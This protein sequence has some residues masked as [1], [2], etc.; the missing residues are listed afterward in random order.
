MCVVGG[1]FPEVLIPPPVGEPA[2]TRTGHQVSTEGAPD[3]SSHGGK[4]RVLPL[5]PPPIPAWVPLRGPV[6][7]HS[8]PGPN[9]LGG[10]GPEEPS[11]L[12]G[13]LKQVAAVQPHS[14]GPVAQLAQG[15]GYGQEVG[16]TA[17]AGR[18]KRVGRLQLLC[19]APR[20]CL[21]LTSS[22]CR[23]PAGPGRPG[24][25]PGH[26]PQR[27]P[28]PPGV[29]PAPPAPGGRTLA[30]ATPPRG[31]PDPPWGPDQQPEPTSRERHQGRVGDPECRVGWGSHLAGG[32]MRGD[33]TCLP[34]SQC[35]A[36][37][38]PT[39]PGGPDTWSAP[40]EQGL[41]RPSPRQGQALESVLW[42]SA[43]QRRVLTGSGG[44][45]VPEKDVTKECAKVPATGTPLSCP[46]S[47]LLLPSKPGPEHRAGLGDL[48]PWGGGAPRPGLPLCRPALPWPLP[49]R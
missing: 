42:S 31:W 16:K 23:C 35:S 37:Y 22:H 4:G 19:R 43:G 28:A 26:R 34:P 47:T 41:D 15:Q 7:R 17:S 30:P 2:L 36:G 33:A 21:G 24:E 9:P 32:L 14:H 45:S 48:V 11:D 38:L 29:A 5:L 13:L 12:P 40:A 49:P 10:S 25:R 1:A 44:T 20:G 3:Q 27:L 8:T 6:H 46:A 39:G 18:G